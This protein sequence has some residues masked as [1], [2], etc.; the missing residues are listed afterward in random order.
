MKKL[1][2]KILLLIY[3]AANLVV[4][5]QTNFNPYGLN[6]FIPIEP[7][8]I[9]NKANSN[10]LS[11]AE[12]TELNPNIPAV[13]YLGVHF[14]NIDTGWACGD[15]GR[16]IKTT[17]GGKSWFMASTPVNQLL[18]KIH[19][20]DGQTVIAAGYD[21]T[22]LRSTDG[23]ENFTQIQTGI[24]SGT[25]LW[26]IKMVS[27][28]T[29]WICG[30]N[31]T[32]LKTTNGGTTW[33]SVTTPGYTADFWGIDFLDADNGYIAANGKVLKTTDG[34]ESWGVI[35]AGDA[36]PLIAI[37]AIDS[38][39]VAASGYGA[40]GYPA[41]NIYSSNGG[42]TWITGGTLATKNAN[43]I[44][45]I[46]KDT[47]YVVQ[48]NSGLYK[49][50][51]RGQTWNHITNNIGEYDFTFLP[52]IT[53][54]SV[55]TSMKI[56]KASG[57]TDVWDKAIINENLKDVFF[58]SEV[59]GFAV[60]PDNNGILFKT[61]DSGGNWEKVADAPGGN[62][63]TFTDSLTGFIG[64][65]EIG[66]TPGKIYKTT[67]GGM[68][69]YATNIANPIGSINKIFFLNSTIGWAVSGYSS[70]S[71]AKILNTTDGGE[72]WTVQQQMDNST[73]FTGVFFLNTQNGWATGRNIW[74][75]TNSG[76]NWIKRVDVPEN[77]FNDVYFSNSINGWA[78]AS[79][80]MYST[81]DGGNNWTLS[82]QSLMNSTNFE[83]LSD[84]HFI[85]AGQTM[86]ES[87][88]A[89]FTWQNI[90]GEV[91]RTFISLHAPKKYLAF[92]VG[93]SGVIMKYYNSS[94]IP[95]EL[96]S[97]S[98]ALLNNKEIELKWSTA[99]ET[100]NYGFEIERRGGQG[101]TNSL[102]NSW[103][104]IGFLNG[105]G[106]TTE[107]KSYSFIDENVKT[108]KYI[109]RLKQIDFDGK[110]VYSKE[111]IVET[112]HATSLPTKCELYQNYPNPFN[113]VTTIKFAI[114]TSPQ[115]PLLT[116]ERGSGDV[117]TVTVFDVLGRELATLVNEPKQPGT[118][119]VQWD[120][121]G[122]SSGIYFIK[123]TSGQFSA[124]R[125]MILTK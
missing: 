71:Q 43:C 48:T 34:G 60:S 70:N 97:F 55:G 53:G 68:N 14:I 8:K 92:A 4:Y 41:K 56:F 115:I 31:N 35:P 66:S 98:A 25:N 3:M 10:N 52:G 29:G 112:L 75:T 32:L 100:N 13:D 45:F 24:I 77:F 30:T 124:I 6:N 17:N 117:A 39:H 46:N 57:D 22:I 49:T 62:V 58:I 38:L 26:G 23:G 12:W 28:S 80:Q 15:Y 82:P 101:Q 116:K 27:S 51:N 105:N 121:A 86:L 1:I 119:E 90:T 42:F 36:F 59:K 74:Q 103:K 11:T 104:I 122:Y 40:T 9:N 2:T 69:W 73:G 109:Y 96:I 84:S 44:H 76:T 93:N 125:K 5:S 79:N 67:N 114:P 63:I 81:T 65:R 47:G 87:T 107:M 113:P 111:I 72:N 120:A 108:G 54:F 78:I 118:Y 94:L 19:S 88:D 64:S 50:T 33:Q 106:T 95:V 110:Y 99:S 91:G 7:S 85:I 102:S 83:T 20:F 18:L 89:G 16:I 21:K 123:L 61:E 37:H